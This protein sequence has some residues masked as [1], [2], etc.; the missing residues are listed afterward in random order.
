MRFRWISPSWIIA[1]CLCWSSLV[2]YEPCN[3]PALLQYGIGIFNTRRQRHRQPQGSIE[4]KWKPVI[5]TLRPIVGLMLTQKGS[6]YVYG[7][8]GLDLFLS[9][10]LVLTPSFAP[11]FYWRGNGKEL[12]F[13]LEFRSSIELAAVFKT[14]ARF[15]VQFYHISN[16]S[17]GFKNPGEES[18]VLFL[19]LPL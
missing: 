11:G 9:K 5:Y 16:A 18:F 8:A 6:G 14:H 15:G 7:G 4:Y 10:R 1:S 13:P 17:L 2:A 12:G 3:A 19:A